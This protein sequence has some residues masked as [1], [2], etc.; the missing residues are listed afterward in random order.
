MH[1]FPHA[2]SRAS[3]R[4]LCV[5]GMSA[6]LIGAAIQPAFAADESPQ[7]LPIG[8]PDRRDK[9][10]SVVLDAVVDTRDGTV[11]DPSGLVKRLE[12]TRLLL[13]GE[14]HTSEEYHRVQEMV[15]RELHRNGRKVWVGLEMMPTDQ[16][17]SLDRWVAGELSEEEYLEEGGWYEHWGYNWE[18]Y[19]PIFQEAR[20]SKMPML[21]LNVPRDL[22]SSVRTMGFDGLEETDRKRL[23][24][25]IQGSNDEYQRHFM[26]YFDSDSG[27]HAI[28]GDM[29]EGF[30]RSQI[31]WDASMAWASVQA[32]KKD[33]DA[34]LVVLVGS[35]HV[36]YGIGIERQA[37]PWLEGEIKTL[38]PVPVAYDGE[39]VETV[40]ASYA[41]FIWGVAEER[42]SR[43][44][45]LGIS[46]RAGDDGVRSVLFVDENS[47]SAALNLQPGDLILSVDGHENPGAAALRRIMGDKRWGDTVKLVWSR[48]GEEKT[49]TIYL[50]RPNEGPNE[51]GEEETVE[52]ADGAAEDAADSSSGDAE[53]ADAGEGAEDEKDEKDEKSRR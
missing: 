4:A 46:S 3:I 12:K 45:S 24:P 17:E 34:I 32:L 8:D 30:L 37:T 51:E 50:R 1:L 29:M 28:E 16:Q 48:D 27:M 5:L 53:S 2:S 36:A 19:R 18:Y 15:L 25:E 38:I 40:S 41:D 7:Q 11:L 35:G 13:V 33:P 9:Q 22:V 14:S 49:D 47:P 26:S 21:G 20:R 31:A 52:E 43:F 44:P 42:W 23:P 39:P 10:A 6:I